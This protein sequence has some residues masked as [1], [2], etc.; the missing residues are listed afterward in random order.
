MTWCF[1]CPL[2]SWGPLVKTPLQLTKTFM[3]FKLGLVDS[4]WPWIKCL[5]HILRR[6]S[7]PPKK[8]EKSHYST[9][10]S[11]FFAKKIQHVQQLFQPMEAWWFNLSICWEPWMTMKLATNHPSSKSYT[12][13][14]VRFGRTVS[15]PIFF[16]NLTP[17]QNFENLE[18][19]F[20]FLGWKH[21]LLER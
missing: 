14:R 17:T 4:S 18:F 6:D 19:F 1:C 5:L 11:V 7:H 20:I 15:W 21:H 8:L 16:E 12:K 9:G 2:S 10:K 3:G 13:W